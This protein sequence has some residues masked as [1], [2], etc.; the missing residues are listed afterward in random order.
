MWCKF[1]KRRLQEA[2]SADLTGPDADGC[3]AHST[4][5]RRPEGCVRCGLPFSRVT[6]VSAPV[7]GHYCV[8]V[9][10]TLDCEKR[11]VDLQKHLVPL[12]LPP[13]FRFKQ[14]F[15]HRKM[16]SKEEFRL[17]EEPSSRIRKRY[18]GLPMLKWHHGVISVNELKRTLECTQRKS[19]KLVEAANQQSTINH[20]IPAVQN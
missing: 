12:R 16:S 13:F 17:G 1:E 14:L 3:G 8:S 19:D 9:L 10:S 5:V 6:Y 11:S 18:G 20:T 4:S 2:L 15:S 7:S